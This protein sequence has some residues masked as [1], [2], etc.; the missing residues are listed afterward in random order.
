MFNKGK[1]RPSAT[2]RR[3]LQEMEPRIE[4]G[5]STRG[6]KISGKK[7]PFAYQQAA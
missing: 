5:S 2:P 3:S 4:Q 7:L 1:V 6:G